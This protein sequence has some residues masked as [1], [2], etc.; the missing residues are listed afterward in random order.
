MRVDYGLTS[1]DYPTLTTHPNTPNNININHIGFYIGLASKII[2]WQFHQNKP[3]RKQMNIWTIVRNSYLTSMISK[4]VDVSSKLTFNP[5]TKKKEFNLQG[6]DQQTLLQLNKLQSKN[7]THISQFRF[8]KFSEIEE[9]KGWRRWRRTYQW[10]LFDF[11]ARIW[12]LQMDLGLGV[13]NF[14]S[15]PPFQFLLEKWN[16]MEMNEEK[17]LS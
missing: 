11:G 12:S 5:K 4:K 3:N 8:R 9:E 14:L 17:G 16:E 10:I 15:L 2:I 7:K 13:S 6:E 1:N